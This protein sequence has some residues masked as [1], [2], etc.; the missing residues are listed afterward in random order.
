MA[1]IPTNQN[2]CDFKI[3]QYMIKISLIKQGLKLAGAI[4][5]LNNE[6]ALIPL[7]NQARVDELAHEVSGHG[8]L[9]VLLLKLL[10]LLSQLHDLELRSSRF[11]LLLRGLFLLGLD[12]GLGAT[13]LAAHLEHI[14]RHA[15]RYYRI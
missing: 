1:L 13:T 6:L 8:A 12:L 3:K 4:G 14:G 2:F 10:N 5:G 11:S 9:L 15:L 7:I